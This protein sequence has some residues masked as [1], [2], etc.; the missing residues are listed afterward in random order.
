[1]GIK[2][3]R[4]AIVATVADAEGSIHQFISYHLSIGFS[5]LYLFVDDNN[6]EV[7]RTAKSFEQVHLLIRNEDLHELWKKTPAYADEKKRPLI[8]QEVMVRQEMNFFVASLLAKR[9]SIDWL[10]H[11]DLDE[12]FYPN[13]INLQE[14]FISLQRRGI[15]SVTFL[16]YESL[17][18]SDDSES[19]YL[20]TC[21][22]KLN[23]FRRGHLV[24]SKEQRQYIKETPWL[25]DKYFHFY[26]NGK[27]I[28]NLSGKKIAYYDVHSIMADGNRLMGGHDDPVILHFPCA[29]Y[30]DFCKKYAR[31][32]DFS[33]VWMGYQR[34]GDFIETT[35]LESRDVFKRG[36]TS[37]IKKYYTENFIYTDEKIQS[38][39]DKKMAIKIDFH[40]DVLE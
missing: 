4:L 13:H 8:D 35:H 27:S 40:F 6:E 2:A 25:R 28:I 18:V 23:F 16:N 10:L 39:I 32:G 30:I 31:L 5:R 26:Q 12:L 29:S 7:I 19:I 17:L 24:F 3:L 34:V 21:F 15:A 1:M 37:L 9:E 22:F 14:Y 11:I 36:D 38:L 20:S 33:D